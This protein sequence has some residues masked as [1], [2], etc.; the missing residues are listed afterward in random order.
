VEI[1][2][3]RGANFQFFNGVALF[4]QY[5]CN[6]FRRGARPMRMRMT[7]RTNE[8][9]PRNPGVAEEYFT[10]AGKIFLSNSIV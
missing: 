9:F 7:G 1:A 5:E 8:L 4:A 6:F 3:V 2:W 10:S